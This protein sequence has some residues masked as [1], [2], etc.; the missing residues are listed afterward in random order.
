M[1]VRGSQGH[2]QLGKQLGRGGEGSVYEVA[3]N[4]NL[5]AKIYAS[6][7]SAERS[8]KLLAMA[9]VRTPALEQLTA[10]PLDV[11]KSPDG[12]V[13]GFV[14]VNLH[15]SKDIHKLYSPK[16]RLAEFPSAD[17]RMVVRAALNTARAFALLHQ[18]GHLVG[19]VNHGGVRV[20]P[21]ALVRLIDCD[22]FQITHDGRTFLCEVGVQDFT[23]PE[24]HGKA[25][26]EVVRTAN[27]DN[28]G[29]A[30]LIFQMLLNG[31]HPFA[32]RFSGAGDMPIE[33]AIPEFRYAYSVSAASKGMRPPPLSTMPQAASPALAALWERA[34]GQEGVRPGARPTAQAWVEKLSELE[35]QFAKCGR[36]ASHYY[37]KAQ[38][39][40]PWCQIEQAVGR[41][42]FG[43][44]STASAP[45]SANV[46]VGAIWIEISAISLP[47]LPPPPGPSPRQPSGAALL[48]GRRRKSWLGMGWGIGLTIF[49]LGIALAMATGVMGHL[50]WMFVGWLS[51]AWVASRGAGDSSFFTNAHYQ[52]KTRYDDLRNRWENERKNDRGLAAKKQELEKVRT[53]LLN[54]PALRQRKEAELKANRHKHA[55]R[56]YLDRFEIENAALSGIGPAKTMML[57][58]FGIETAADVTEHAVMQVPGFGP[59]LTKRLLDWRRSHERNFQFNPSSMVDPREMAELNRAMTARQIELTNALRAGRDA[60]LTLRQTAIVNRHTLEEALKHA[61]AVY[62]QAA[63]EVK[64]IGTL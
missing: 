63:A 34:F 35:Q 20:S 56:A 10:W 51:G 60:L 64:A 7:A 44:P 5:A 16:S 26:R 45:A 59:A 19:D 38:T 15:G 3:G 33:R 61:A 41:A 43:F 9:Q 29:L 24:L 40:C 30:V 22:S 13:R 4:A 2:V 36:R 21:N 50:M 47:P 31:R 48:I 28:F 49:S 14:M 62:G 32:G 6:P 23:P 8:S 25:F 1:D 42:L 54:L 39:T 55:L 46:D 52:A 18:S 17:W 27:H 58:S 53:E 11:L 37:H 57:E 12:K